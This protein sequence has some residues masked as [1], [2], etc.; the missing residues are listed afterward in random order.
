MSG[1]HGGAGGWDS[2]LQVLCDTSAG[3]VTTFL[4]RFLGSGGAA[5]AVDTEL[6]GVTPYAVTGTVVSC[7]DPEATPRTDNSVI[8]CDDG[9]PFIRVYGY[10][11]DGTVDSVTDFELDGTTPYL[12][13]GQVGTCSTPVDLATVE[14]NTAQ[15]RDAVEDVAS[16]LRTFVDVEQEVLCDDVLGDGTAVVP[17][18][19]VFRYDAENGTFLGTDDLTLLGAPYTTQGT[20]QTCV[21]GTADTTCTTAPGELA[22][23]VTPADATTGVDRSSSILFAFPAAMDPAV[24]SVRVR[25][26][27]TTAIVP[28]TV[29]WNGGNDVATFTPSGQMDPAAWHEAFALDGAKRAADGCIDTQASSVKSEFQTLAVNAAQ[30]L[31]RVN[32]AEPSGPLTIQPDGYAPIGVYADMDTDGG[33]WMLMM[34]RTLGPGG[35]GAGQP[36]MQQW[37]SG[38][39]ASKAAVESNGGIGY[40]AGTPPE[41]YDASGR[42]VGD[43]TSIPALTARNQSFGTAFEVRQAVQPTQFRYQGITTVHDRIIDFASSDQASLTYMITGSGSARGSSTD[44]TPLSGQYGPH[45]ALMPAAATQW[46]SVNSPSNVWRAPY[47]AGH[48]TTGGPRIDI[49]QS[50]SLCLKLLDHNCNEATAHHGGGCCSPGAQIRF[51]LR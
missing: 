32:P 3:T 23:T 1:T 8:L 14:S 41:A 10:D 11:A 30:H 7:T 49:Y 42:V 51:W 34:Q 19:R 28:G 13:G 45:T 6:D 22:P 31:A 21:G 15:T 18:V 5:V 4:R 40:D 44:F 20:V 12:A 25:N 29:T 26:R 48:H 43:N 37:G 36:N 47:Y 50:G 33:G 16:V 9:T 39:W 35:Y 46:H 27:D 17:F 24:T 2:E 38:F